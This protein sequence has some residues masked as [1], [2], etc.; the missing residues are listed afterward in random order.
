MAKNLPFGW[1]KLTTNRK[2]YIKELERIHDIQYRVGKQIDI[3]T[4]R[5]ITKQEIEKLKQIRTADVRLY[6]KEV[7]R[8]EDLVDDTIQSYFTTF[9]YNNADDIFKQEKIE[10]YAK[11]D[12]SVK[13]QQARFNTLKD[14]WN[15]AIAREGKRAVAQRLNDRSAKRIVELIENAI[16]PSDEELA[17]A[18]LLEFVNLINGGAVSTEQA[19]YYTHRYEEAYLAVG[20]GR[21]EDED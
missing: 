21:S 8:A 9:N 17:N 1:T 14:V 11:D 16:Y 19:E 5:V 15:D 6:G 4:P 2:E 3:Q 10:T 7:P 20:V 13:R 12:T 18:S